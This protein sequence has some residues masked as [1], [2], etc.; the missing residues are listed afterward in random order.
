MNT[1]GKTTVFVTGATGLVGSHLVERLTA[2]GVEVRCLVRSSSRTELLERLGVQ[3]VVGDV[4]DEPARLREL[5]GDASLVFHCAAMVDDWASREAMVRVNVEGTRNLLESCRGLP[6]LRRFVMVGS[7]VVLGMGPQIH[8]DETAPMVHTGD[9]YNYTKILATEMAM[10]YA[11]EHGVPVVVCQPPYIYGPRDQQFFPR[12]F[13]ALKSGRF[14]YLGDGNQPL[15]LVYVANL[16]EALLLAA[17]K[18]GVQGQLFLVTDGESV[19]RR[20]LVEMVCE[21]MGYRKPTVCV[22]VAVARALLPLVEWLGK[23]RGKRPIL[24]R[25]QMKFLS[26]PLTF[27]IAKARTVLGYAPVEPPRE[28]LRKTIRWYREHHK[29]MLPGG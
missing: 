21:E 23:V 12:V 13:E 20:E 15:T 8:F 5:I 24:N 27:N 25:F 18:D 28:S 22:P 14:K 9:N 16:V 4:T 1:G 7:M 17:A 19:T 11:R 29:E 26:T 10:K 6:G 2:E 3:R